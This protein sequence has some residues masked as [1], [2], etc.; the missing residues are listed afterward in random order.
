MTSTTKTSKKPEVQ[1]TKGSFYELKREMSRGGQG[2]IYRTQFPQTLIKGFTNKDELARQHWRN[3][4]AWLIRQDLSDLK[5]AR[6]VALLA[7][8]RCGYVM[9][10]MDGLVPLQSLLD[11]FLNAGEESLAD[12]LQAGGLRRRVRILSQLARTL[13]QL[14][15]RGM[16]YGD[17]SPGNIFV[18]DDPKHAET[19]LIDCDNISLFTHSG[20]TF[21][22]PDYG[23][24]EVIR[25]EALL[26]SLTDIWSFAVIAY[27]LLTHNHPFKGEVISD[28]EPELEEEALRGEHPWINDGQDESNRCYTCLPMQLIEHSRLPELFSRCFEQGRIRASDRPTMAEWLAA[29]TEIDEHLYTCKHCG[30]DT[31]LPADLPAEDVA[32]HDTLCFFCDEPVE[33]ELV[34]FEEFLSVVEGSEDQLSEQVNWI[35]TGRKV[36]LQVGDRKELKRLLPTF[37]YDRWPEDHVR[38]EYTEKGLGIHALPQGQLHLQ[39]GKT[40][41]QL[42]RYQ[43]LKAS[44]RGQNA[45]AFQLHI[46]ELNASHVLWQFKW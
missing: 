28:G 12:Y 41:K 21:H 20:L 22:T 30:G 24:P 3:Q 18:S 9:E 11:S 29:L 35:P 38:L 32:S 33:S 13:N 14:H 26:S 42:A 7:E 10:L 15:S 27:Q 36:W 23:A 46:G 40:I 6:P 31:I 4:I 1:D 43:G 17:L 39:Q 8:P 37:S 2:I 44:L 19:W 25:G 16:L 45:T 34:L 5:L